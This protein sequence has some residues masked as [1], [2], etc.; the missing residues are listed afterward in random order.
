MEALLRKSINVFGNTIFTYHSPAKAESSCPV[1]FIHGSFSCARVFENQL[2]GPLGL[3]MNLI[4]IDLPGHGNSPKALFPE[5]LYT[6]AGLASAV[7]TVVEQ[8]NI[9]AAVFVGVGLGGQILLAAAPKLVG[10]LG[11]VIC[12][13]ALQQNGSSTSSAVYA[14]V[15]PLSSL[16]AIDVAAI[17]RLCYPVNSPAWTSDA[18]RNSDGNFRSRVADSI[19]AQDD[20]AMLADVVASKKP[21]CV[22]QGGSDPT[23]DI[24]KLFSLPFPQIWRSVIQVLPGV[25]A[26][27]ALE[28]PK[29]FGEVIG[30]FCSELFAKHVQ[31][32]V[33]LDDG[34]NHHEGP[35]VSSFRPKHHPG[36]LEHAS[37]RF[38]LPIEGHNEPKY[39]DEK[40]AD[41]DGGAY[42]YGRT[43]AGTTPHPELRLHL[44]APEP[45]PLFKKSDNTN[46]LTAMNPNFRGRVKPG[47]TPHQG[48]RY[49]LVMDEAQEPK[50]VIRNAHSCTTPGTTPHPGARYENTI[51]VPGAT[52]KVPPRPEALLNPNFKGRKVPGTVPNPQSRFENPTPEIIA[53]AKDDAYRPVS[54]SGVR[55]KQPPGGGT[56]FI[57]G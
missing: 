27:L 10:A 36:T 40:R 7:V 4:A 23:V 55:I 50:P 34:D 14:S 52:Q 17:Q 44:N 38:E 16:S 57:F 33:L 53:A 28:S 13:A 11:F 26:A 39:R 43:P 45:E 6:I 54:S 8:L 22:L 37:N 49:E 20:L 41:N 19:G 51:E 29:V 2:C 35:M 1:I 18:I 42:A 25:G 12:N 5:K 56:T 30:Q 31:P 32:F 3:R 21:V 15:S 9:T 47:T 24:L 46:E 48:A